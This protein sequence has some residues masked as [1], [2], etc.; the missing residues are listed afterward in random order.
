MNGLC[1]ELYSRSER[2]GESQQTTTM[3]S[4]RLVTAV[5]IGAM[6]SLSIKSNSEEPVQPAQNPGPPQQTWLAVCVVA[7]CGVAIA[8]IYV[9][10]RKCRPKYYWLC[11]NEEPPNKWVGTCT[12]RECI[13]NGWRKI[14]G[15]YERPEDAPTNAPPITNVV[16]EIMSSAPLNYTVEETKDLQNWTPIYSERTTD[17]EFAYFPTNTAGGMFRIRVTP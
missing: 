4:K 10:A 6:C 7:A 14:G 5:L 12:K 8:G 13:I 17:E 16:S 2:T 11:D 1:P 9:L 3:Q 15:P